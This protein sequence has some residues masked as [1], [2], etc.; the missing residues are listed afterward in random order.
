MTGDVVE[1]RA[2]RPHDGPAEAGQRIGRPTAPASA[3]P[4]PPARSG[5]GAST[6]SSITRS[7][8]GESSSKNPWWAPTT[9]SRGYQRRKPGR[10]LAG[11]RRLG[12]EQVDRLSGQLAQ[13]GQAPD[14][15]GAGHPVGH[16][17]VQGA[18]GEPDAVAVA[19]DEVGAAQRVAQAGG[20]ARPVDDVGV[21][22]H[23][24]PGAPLA[25]PAGDRGAAA[26]RAGRGRSGCR[27]STKTGR[28]RAASGGI[29]RWRAAP[30][31]MQARTLWRASYALDQEN[32]ILHGCGS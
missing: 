24:P 17:E 12:A 27:R 2:D 15:V 19:V 11:D 23:H 4:S 28:G 14:P 29:A 22:V 32:V 21:D 16:V 20:H 1:Q 7:L 3:C 9:S 5:A 18:G 6:M 31:G 25:G 13:R 26:P 30:R 10:G 8:W